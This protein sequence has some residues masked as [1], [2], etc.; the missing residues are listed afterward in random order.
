[1]LTTLAEWRTEMARVT[2]EPD[3]IQ[4]QGLTLPYTQFMERVFARR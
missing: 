3:P 4:S 2:G 1:M